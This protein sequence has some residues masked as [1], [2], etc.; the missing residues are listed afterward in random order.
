MKKTGIVADSHSGITPEQASEL[1]VMVLP[2]P[3]YFGE[4]CFHENLTITRARFFERIE[5]GEKV[6]TT[7]ASPGELMEIWDRALEEFEE[8]LYFP[9]SR[10]LS[11]SCTTATL[12]SQEEKYDGRVFVVDIGRISVPQVCSI[13]D[14][15]EMIEAGRS[16]SF[17]K[18]ILERDQ[19]QFSIYVGVEDIS[20]L[21]RGGRISAATAFIGKMLNIKPM[22]YLHTGLLEKM[23]EC[24]GGARLRKEMIDALKKDV[25]TRFA[26]AAA[27]HRLRL[28]SAACCDTPEETERWKDQVQEAFPDYKVI[29]GDLSLGI[30]CHL[31]PG[32]IGIGCSCTPKWQEVAE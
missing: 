2:M 24:R 32:G 18:S 21:R 13:L 3:F 7:Q 6:S 12:I 27:E 28:I 23:K 29:Y 14:A 20:Y 5:S 19:D 8:I 25:E 15:L 16:A 4:E 10:G 11:G 26:D 1:G 30:A 31:G 17:I 22:L 9:I